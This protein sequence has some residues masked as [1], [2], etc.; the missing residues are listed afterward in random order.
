M[1][2]G[3]DSRLE[4]GRWLKWQSYQF[5]NKSK[6]W[7]RTTSTHDTESKAKLKE[8]TYGV[9]HQEEDKRG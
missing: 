4:C 7:L 2:C 3:Y 6:K 8:E 9:S 5:Q 1:E